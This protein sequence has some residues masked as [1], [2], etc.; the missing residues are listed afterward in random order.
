M[1]PDPSGVPDGSLFDIFSAYGT[2]NTPPQCI[3]RLLHSKSAEFSFDGRPGIVDSVRI[4]INTNDN[5]LFPESP[6]R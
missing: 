1:D 6:D 5:L 2:D 4:P 3:V